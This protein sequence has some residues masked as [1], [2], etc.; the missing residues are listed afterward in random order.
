MIEIVA[1]K[2][3]LKNRTFKVIFKHCELKGSIMLKAIQT[4]FFK[5]N[6]LKPKASF[7]K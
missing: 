7:S 2:A 6:T 3:I 5:E 1:L 4:S